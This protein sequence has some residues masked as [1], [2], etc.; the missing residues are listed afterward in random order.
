MTN[1]IHPL[2]KEKYPFVSKYFETL[3]ENDVDKF[4]QSALKATKVPI[5]AALIVPG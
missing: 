1:L 4:P 2:L 3:I 5:A